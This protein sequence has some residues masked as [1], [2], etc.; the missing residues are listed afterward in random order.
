MTFTYAL[1]VEHGLFKALQAAEA[2]Q[3]EAEAADGAGV[4][5]KRDEGDVE[6]GE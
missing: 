5:R 2:V 4:K 1:G 3:A 6:G